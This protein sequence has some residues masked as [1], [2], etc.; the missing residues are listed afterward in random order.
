MTCAER[1]YFSEAHK[2][3]RPSDR[4]GTVMKIY[5]AA[6]IVALVVFLCGYHKTSYAIDIGAWLVLVIWL[7]FN[8]GVTSN[9]SSNHPPPWKV[10]QQEFEAEQGDQNDE[11]Y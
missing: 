5:G 2:S 6:L 8:R 4:T 11:D 9:D 3:P 10:A 7:K 1:D